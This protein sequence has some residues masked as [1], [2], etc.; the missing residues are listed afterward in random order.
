MRVHRALLLGVAAAATAAACAGI[1]GLRGPS[2]RPFEHRAHTQKGI[3]CLSC[4]TGV[5]KA[6]ETGPLHLPDEAKCRTCHE[7]P[8]D[9][10]PC[11]QCH[12]QPYTAQ[13]LVQTRDHLLFRH[14]RHLA[15]EE[16]GGNCVRCHSDVA[17]EGATL[18]PRMA[19]CLSCHQHS[20]QYD[21]RRCDACHVNLETEGT[22]PQSHLI[23]EGDFVREHGVRAQGQVDL[24]QTCHSESFCASCHGVTTPAL[25]SVMKFDDPAEASVHRAGFRSRHSDA[26][27]AEPGLCTTCHAQ[28]FCRSCHDDK[29]LGAGAELPRSPH[30]P[31]WVSASPG[32]NEHGLAARRD[33]ASCASCHSGPGEALCVSC[34]KVGGVGGNPHPP[35]WD[36][37]R[38]LAD[39][40]C[41]LC[42]QP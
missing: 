42:H 13:D 6:N 20:N 4:H 21:N 22:R 9:E 3:S 33:P 2:G 16:L 19:T 5:D 35:G 11:L 30:P 40:P 36:S 18:R 8:H 27:R 23:H 41:R 24:C 28:Q 31:G 32:G 10:R 1:L 17:Q 29:G 12:G 38:S 15:V 37:D 7:K 26:A 34:H 14:D 25:P 39:L